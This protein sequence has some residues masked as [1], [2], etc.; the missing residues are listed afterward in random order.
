MAVLGLQDPLRPEVP[1]AVEQC[2]RAGGC[3]LPGWPWGQPRWWG[4]GSKGRGVGGS[5]GVTARYSSAP[6]ALDFNSW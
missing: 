6:H 5:P 4:K 3:G 1:H 2:N